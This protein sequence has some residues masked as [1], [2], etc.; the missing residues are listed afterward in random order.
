ML[1]IAKT[2]SVRSI[3]STAMDVD[4]Q[5]LVALVRRRGWCPLYAWGLSAVDRI[6]VQ[7]RGQL[8][9]ISSNLLPKAV[10]VPG[11]VSVPEKIRSRAERGNYVA[12]VAF[13]RQTKRP[14]LLIE[15]ERKS[16]D[17]LYVAC[18]SVT[19]YLA[20]PGYGEKNA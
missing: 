4:L 1:F 7:R 12:W 15:M 20:A 9:Q 10:V 17:A 11:L 19:N 8:S 5:P 2:I 3:L 18:G 13:L 6:V 16:P 14:D